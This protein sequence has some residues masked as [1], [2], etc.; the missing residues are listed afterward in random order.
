MIAEDP[1]RLARDIKGIGFRTADAIAMK[2]GIEK[3]AMIRA[4]AGISFAL[5][6]ALNDGHC[7]L[8]R[9]ELLPMAIKLLEIPGPI[10][11]TALRL[12]LGQGDVVADQVEGRD[13]IFFARLHHAPQSNA[14]RLKAIAQ[15]PFPLPASASHNAI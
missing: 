10:V 15:S 1:Y 12:E 14:S 3:T 9:D 2:L 4:R 11:E 5:T 7:G 13:Y 8:P 6:E